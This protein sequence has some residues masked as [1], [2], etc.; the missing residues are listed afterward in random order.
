MIPKEYLQRFAA[1]V[2]KRCGICQATVEQVLPAVF[3]EIRH[4]LCEGDYKCVYIESFGTFSL[5]ERPEREYPYR[6]K[7][8]NEM[9]RLP[10]KKFIKFYPTR[11]FRQEMEAGS[12]DPSRQ[13][14]R[15]HPDDPMIRKRCHLKYRPAKNGVFKGSTKKVQSQ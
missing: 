7:G 15:R 3:D 11:N 10:A 13:S 6:Y 14:F 5:F 8:A 9:R 12:F 2:V 1:N 4:E